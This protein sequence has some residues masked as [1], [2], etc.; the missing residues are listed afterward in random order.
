MMGARNRIIICAD[1]NLI[2]VE[3]L[4]CNRMMNMSFQ[5]ILL[6][7]L[8]YNFSMLIMEKFN[9][10]AVTMQIAVVHQ[11]M[12]K[13]KKHALNYWTKAK[14]R[15]VSYGWHNHRRAQKTPAHLHAICVTNEWC[16]EIELRSV[17]IGEH[18]RILMHWDGL[19]TMEITIVTNANA[20]LAFF[21]YFRQYC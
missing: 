9:K 3:K 11:R 2:I 10:F 4:H 8:Y 21:F 16:F 7:W 20:A 14:Y 13:H 18:Q 15:C 12:E 17:H 5:P 6:S 19:L 1:A